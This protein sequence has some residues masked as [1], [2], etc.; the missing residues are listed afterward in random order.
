MPYIGKSTDGMGVRSRFLFLADASDTSV[1]GADASGATLSFSDG[2]YVDV[3]LNGVLL[4]AGTD[5]NTSTANTVA[6]LSALAANDEVTVIVYDIFTVGDMVSSSDGGT[7]VGNVAMSGTLGVTGATT[8]AAITASGIIKTDAT[9]D[10]TSTTDGSLQTDGGFSVAKDAVI[11]DDLLMLSDSA[12]I[13]FGADSEVT[14][15]HVAD[16][17]LLLND[18]LSIS[19]AD[20]DDT[21][22][23]ISTDADASGGPALRF[24]RNSSSPAD[25]DTMTT[26]RFEGNNDNSQVVVYNRIRA[27]IS[28]ASDGTEDGIFNIFNMMAG[29][30]RTIFSIKPDEVVFNDES[31]DVDFRVESDNR[32]KALFVNGADGNIGINATPESWHS[33][34]TGI[35]IGDQGFI[36][37]YDGGSTYITTN[38]YYDASASTWKAKET[39]TGGTYSASADGSHWWT[40][41]ASVSADANATNTTIATM[42]PSRFLKVYGSYGVHTSSG[43]WH[44]LNTAEEANDACIHICSHASRSAIGNVVYHVVADSN[45]NAKFYAGY[46]GYTGSPDLEFYARNDGHVYADNNF[47]S[48]G[49]DYAEFF[50]WKDGN[51]SSEDRRGYSVVLDGNQIRKATSDDSASNI[52]GVIS[53]NPSVVGDADGETWNSK[54]LK[55]DYGVYIRED[56]EIYQWVERVDEAEQQIT[57]YKGYVPDGV[58]VPDDATTTKTTVRKLNPDYDKSKDYERREDR[59]EWSYVGMMG[60]LRMRKGQPIGDRWI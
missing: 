34:F 15:T 11:G 18:K 46:S 32:T 31:Q 42:N 36:G 52:I 51:S 47:N 59:K 25:D 17:G 33:N 9:T 28:D 2:A 10:A 29:T 45:T 27:D 14:L 7:F 22:E 56:S 4:K 20:N 21:L 26:I 5:Y 60:K 44:E 55:D 41:S 43:T 54:Y 19:T 30:E 35:D 48:G 40:M 49:A 37:H 12:A 16:T 39:G 23:L 50:E 57:Y 6:G 8:T 24:Y 3:Y 58:T 38:R 1:S 13:K 53:G